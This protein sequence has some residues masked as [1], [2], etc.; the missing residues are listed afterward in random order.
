MKAASRE[1]ASGNS[2]KCRSQQRLLMDQHKNLT[3]FSEEGTSDPGIAGL[4]YFRN[5]IDGPM[6]DRLIEA[7]DRQPWENSLKRQVQQYGYRYDYKSQTIDS[8]HL[9]GPL[10][11]WIAPIATLLHLRGIVEVAVDQAIV[12]E[13]LPGQGIARHIDRI[14]CFGETIAILSL[15]SRVVMDFFHVASQKQSRLLLEP[16]SL[17]VLKG[18][19]RYEWQHGI[20]A[21]KTDRFHGNVCHRGRR[22]SLT[23]RKVLSM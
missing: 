6:Q 15:G 16:G 5:F 11:D 3:L 4:A 23:F 7:I 20:A 13:Y 21:R 17:L 9:L 22:I 18:P 2:S 8:T 14:S 19:A 10:P 12:N 1:N